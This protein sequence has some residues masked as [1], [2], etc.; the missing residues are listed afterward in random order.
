MKLDKLIALDGT[1]GWYARN[2]LADD[3]FRE[4]I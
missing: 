3:A 4:A 1:E 2:I